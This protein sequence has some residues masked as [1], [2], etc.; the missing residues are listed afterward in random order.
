MHR[1]SLQ[2]G[3]LHR[4]STSC[5]PVWNV[6]PDT[7][8]YCNALCRIFRSAFGKIH[9]SGRCLD[10]ITICKLHRFREQR[11]WIQT[12]FEHCCHG[13]TWRHQC[14]F[15]I[16]CMNATVSGFQSM[17]VIKLIACMLSV[18][19]IVSRGHIRNPKAD[20]AYVIQHRTVRTHIRSDN[21]VSTFQ[22]YR[23]L[24][25]LK[26]PVFRFFIHLINTSYNTIS[27]THLHAVTISSA[28]VPCIS[29]GGWRV[30]E[31]LR[32]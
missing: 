19:Y 9:T 16:L 25:A 15:D 7:V 14:L 28:C 2:S 12:R 24:V 21:L 31:G 1:R 32:G 27:S 23:Q 5:S 10:N 20:A 13:R 26:L 11:S 6:S 4:A 22:S 17:K 8:P 29:Q 18:S 30:F 3:S